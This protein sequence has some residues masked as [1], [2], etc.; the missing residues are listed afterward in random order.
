[1]NVIVDQ[2]IAILQI[3]PFGN[4]IGGNQQIDLALCGIPVIL[5]ASC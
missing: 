2:V 4:T 5:S 1:M 3:L